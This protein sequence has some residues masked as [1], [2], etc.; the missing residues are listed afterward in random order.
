MDTY[1]YIYIF[2]CIYTRTYRHGHVHAC[3]FQVAVS[4][5]ISE[6]ALFQNPEKEPQ[7]PSPDLRDLL[8]HGRFQIAKRPWIL[9]NLGSWAHRSSV[10]VPFR[11]SLGPQDYV[12]YLMVL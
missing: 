8:R 11:Q 5:S 3:L 12:E 1:V 4:T 6:E 7:P 9:N 2:I 10:Q